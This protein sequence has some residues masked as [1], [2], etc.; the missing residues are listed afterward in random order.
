MQIVEG[1]QDLGITNGQVL[2]VHII[3]EAACE[4]INSGS[5][6]VWHENTVFEVLEIVFPAVTL[7]ELYTKAAAE[8]KMLLTG[9]KNVISVVAW[10]RLNSAVEK[11]LA[12]EDEAAEAEMERKMEAG[13]DDDEVF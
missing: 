1:E 5:L 4:L 7:H 6:A 9:F 3:G 10:N 13:E 2:G 12:A 8:A 11:L